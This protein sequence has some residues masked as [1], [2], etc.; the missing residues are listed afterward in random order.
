MGTTTIKA[1]PAEVVLGHC[2]FC[3]SSI[4]VL[5]MATSTLLT[6]FGEC[7]ACRR[8]TIWTGVEASGSRGSLGV[9]AQRRAA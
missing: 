5:V 3:S 2:E 4:D 7:T 6:P 9:P 1:R 8:F